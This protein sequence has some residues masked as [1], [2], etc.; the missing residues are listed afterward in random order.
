MSF[1]VGIGSATFLLAALMSIIA[2][3]VVAGLGMMATFFV[4][5]GVSVMVIGSVLGGLAYCF[6]GLKKLA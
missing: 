1:L 6:S 5:V 3:P 2:L 4:A